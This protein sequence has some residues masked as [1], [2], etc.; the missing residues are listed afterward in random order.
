[1]RTNVHIAVMV[2]FALANSA[3][4]QTAVDSTA[5]SSARVHTVV[6]GEQYRAGSIHRFLLGA[7]YRGLWTTPIQVHELDLRAFAGGLRPTRR[8][9]GQQT[10]G[11]GMKGADGRDYTFRGLDKDPTE[12]LPDELHGTIV[13]RLLQ[14]QIASSLPGGTVAVSPILRAAGVLHSE[15]ILVV[16]PDDSLLGEFRKD[17][18]GLLGTFEEFPRATGGEPGTFGAVEIRN[19]EEMW[20]LLD[21]SPA[22]HPDS[23]AFL[24]ARLVDLLIGDWDRHRNQWRWARIPGKEK[25]QPIAEDRDQAFVRFQGLLLSAGRVNQPQFV[26][27]KDKYPGIEGLTWNGRDVDRRILADLEKPVWDQAARDLQS[28]ITDEVIADAVS[29]LP[30]EY[31][32]REGEA[33]TKALR[34]RRDALPEITDRFYRF[35][36]HEVDIRATDQDEIAHVA[37]AE[38]GDLEVAVSLRS[39]AGAPYVR[40]VFHA[41]ETDE[42]RI[43]LGAGADSV[44]TSGH[45]GITVRAVGG[46]GVDEMNDSQG[47]GL[48]V[49]D[50][51][52]TRVQRG[53]G[54]KVDTRPY[55]P[56]PAP[57]NAPWIPPRDWG[58]RN[59]WYPFI[60]GN[61]DLGVLFML[62]FESEGYGFR[63]D[64]F[65][66]RHTFRVGYATGAGGFGADYR[67][68]FQHENSRASHELYV[69]GSGL[70]FLHFYGFG[71]ETQAPGDE[72]FYK[73]KQS[74]YRIE[75]SL[76]LPV[77]PKWMAH[78]RANVTYAKTKLE[79]DHFIDTAPPYGADDFLQAGAGV[80]LSLDTR[81]SEHVPTRGAHVVADGTVFPEVWDVASTFEEVHGEVA[82]YQSISVLSN[83]VLALRAGGRKVWGTF[84]YHEAAYIGGGRTVRG[85]PQQ[86]FAGDASVFGNA[87]LRIPLTRIYIFVPGNLGI[88]GLADVGR[89]YLE[90][91][92]SDK[93]HS[94]FGG[95]V[96]CSF[97]STANTAS[98]SVATSDE[99]TRVYVVAGLAF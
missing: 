53:D 69:R 61:T 94:G 52:S 32:A 67:G 70:D 97:V 84:P 47:T 59:I 34:A 1:L 77:G 82:F 44:V 11:L 75:P 40:R 14:D 51:A 55:T 43:Y 87:E 85:I 39:D 62:N 63:K 71:N 3:R 73:V 19:G 20:K 60:G 45:S 37:H 98:L 31:Q 79:G 22:T 57:E 8:V 15:P 95:G 9:G 13:D 96:W 24:T 76:N 92:S 88:F 26:S 41:D 86:R 6:A 74:L 7:D 29:R 30:A 28:R 42:V 80:G 58:R 17:F 72:D 12:I 65:A 27:F 4:A 91:E 35:L 10:L 93:W 46:D 23:R 50:D 89:V 81:D 21:E 99:G 5:A 33:I 2:A 49:S 48:R 25:W 68:E 78:L 56:P 18:G 83:P 16:M 66:D 36:A 38:N 54:T 90:G 64:P